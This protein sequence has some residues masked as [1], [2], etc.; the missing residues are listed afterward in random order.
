MDLYG[1]Q[2]A[3]TVEVPGANT[4][5]IPLDGLQFQ[6]DIEKSSK[7]N[8]NK[9]DLTIM[10][11]GP[12][13]RNA[14]AA[15]TE[16]P[17]ITLEAGYEGLVEQ[18]FRGDADDVRQERQS[19]TIMT[20]FECGDGSKALRQS[21]INLSF[22]PGQSAKSIVEQ[23]F[24]ALKGLGVAIG[25]IGDFVDKQFANGFSFSGLTKDLLD[26]LTDDLG[27]DWSIQDGVAQ[28]LVPGTATQETRILLTPQTGLL[29]SPTPTDQGWE[30]PSL[31]LPGLRPG[32][33]IRVESETVTGDF[34][35]RRV[36]MNGDT[37]GAPWRAATEVKDLANG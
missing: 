16:K 33:E 35:A 19:H 17:I 18:L 31:L 2:A 6:F 24:E 7:G 30:L 26:Q 36:K 29:G 20:R 21:K 15:A 13:N 1:R 23:A 28:A 4:F 8:P 10:N 22:E 3:L 14:I 37:R 9:L 12:D 5:R 25:E 11:L 27:V 34:V 32:R